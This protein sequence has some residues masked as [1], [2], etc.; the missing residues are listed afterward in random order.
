MGYTHSVEEIQRYFDEFDPLDTGSLN[1]DALSQLLT[2]LNDGIA[3]L[4][5][6]IDG[7]LKRADAIGDGVLHRPELVQARSP[8]K[9]HVSLEES[10]ELQPCLLSTSF[11]TR[12]LYCMCLQAISIWYSLDG[13]QKD[14]QNT[15]NAITKR[16]N[17]QVN[18]AAAKSA[19]CSVQ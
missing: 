13:A 12:A 9:K 15:F 1:R 18:T 8:P 10:A 2:K 17:E 11:L 16:Q 19:C 4:P 3:P 7:V 14:R 6:D 5:V